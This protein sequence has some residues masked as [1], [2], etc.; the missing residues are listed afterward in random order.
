MLAPTN[1]HCGIN[2]FARE[3]ESEDYSQQPCREQNKKAGI[4]CRYR[5]GCALLLCLVLLL[6]GLVIDV[7][8]YRRFKFVGECDIVCGNHSW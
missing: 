8:G 5:Y 3:S 2:Y 7:S 1:A 4:V 6:V